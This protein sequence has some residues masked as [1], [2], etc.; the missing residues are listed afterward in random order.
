MP[1]NLQSSAPHIA[2]ASVWSDGLVDWG[3]IP[4][5]I[6]GESRTSGK[7]LYKGVGGRP[8]SGVWICTPGY[9]N[10]QVTSDEL[11]HFLDGRCTYIHESGEVIEIAP[12][13]TAF[14]PEGWQGTCRVHETV[15]KVYMIR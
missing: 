11:C 7:V 6:E 9:W 5:M 3:V 14:F 8:E 12:D 1:T 2:N 15:R 13:T 4:T 10:C